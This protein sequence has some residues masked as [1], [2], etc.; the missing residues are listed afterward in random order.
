MERK[1]LAFC[2]VFP[3]FESKIWV[4]DMRVPDNAPTSGWLRLQQKFP[5]LKEYKFKK[6]PNGTIAV[7]SFLGFT[8]TFV[9]IMFVMPK[10]Y[11]EYYRESQTQKRN[12]IGATNREEL[13][14]G[15]RPWSD[16][17]DRDRAQKWCVIIGL[18]FL[19]FACQYFYLLL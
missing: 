4:L 9:I 18:L 5:S 1:L 2:T 11:N 8:S 6:P 17:F 12:L 19:L 15:M 7:I 10:Y 14:Q 13:A 3:C 16:P